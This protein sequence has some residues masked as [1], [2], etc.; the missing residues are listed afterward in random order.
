MWVC[1]VCV[2]AK[3]SD[4]C[5]PAT[6]CEIWECVWLTVCVWCM[7]VWVYVCD[8]C[9]WCVWVSVCVWCMCEWCMCVWVYV[10]D[11]CD[12]TDTA[13]KTKNHTS[14]WGTTPTTCRSHH[15]I[16]SA[17]RDSQQPSRI[18]FLFL[19]R[20][21]PPCA[22]LLVMLIYVEHLWSSHTTKGW[23]K[24]AMDF[25]GCRK[26]LEWLM[27]HR[28]RG[29]CV[30]QVDSP[31]SLW[32]TWTGLLLR[33]LRKRSARVAVSKVRI[34]HAELIENTCTC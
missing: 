30:A 14:M 7:C 2:S 34:L 33:H 26:H 20:A 27:N 19:K 3:S 9:V 10:C 25:E 31:S 21:P 32:V 4:V 17:S 22:V 16:S 13:L 28:R 29:D 1:D 8:V 5:V 24:Y 12:G 11:V 18:G 15:W 6:Q 23:W